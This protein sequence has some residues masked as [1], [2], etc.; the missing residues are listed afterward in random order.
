MYAP[1]S[2]VKYIETLK[3]PIERYSVQMVLGK[4]RQLEAIGV[5]IELS[6]LTKPETLSG[7]QRVI[8]GYIGGPQDQS[9]GYL[10]EQPDL[11]GYHRRRASDRW[12]QEYRAQAGQGIYSLYGKPLDLTVLSGWSSKRIRLLLQLRHDAT[13]LVGSLKGKGDETSKRCQFCQVVDETMEHIFDCPQIANERGNLSPMDLYNP[14]RYAE[15]V[16][17]IERVVR[18]DDGD[19]SSGE[20]MNMAQ[21]TRPINGYIANRLVES[22]AES[23][24]G[25]EVEE[26][27]V[28]QEEE[29]AAEPLPGLDDPFDMA[30]EDLEGLGTGIQGMN[31]DDFY[32]FLME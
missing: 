29:I 8:N 20:S 24:G 13:V 7:F 9:L 23:N 3:G 11:I 27:I 5:D 30:P 17:F 28:G 2:A 31:I 10:I 12:E 14:K 32:D 19:P 4:M 25:L 26:E 16:S 21:W 15:V 6:V 22:A 1:S 18:V